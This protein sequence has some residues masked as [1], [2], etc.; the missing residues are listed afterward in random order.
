MRIVFV[1]L[2]AAFPSWT[3]RVETFRNRNKLDV[4]EDIFNL[5]LN[6]GESVHSKYE[7]PSHP[8]QHGKS[9]N[10]KAESYEHIFKLTQGV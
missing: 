9:K 6:G 8:H 4:T 3:K 2:L 7:Y 10:I 1:L 5:N